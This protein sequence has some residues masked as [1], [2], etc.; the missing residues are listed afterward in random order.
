MKIIIIGSVGSGKTTLAKKLSKK[1]NIPYYEI[2]CIVHDDNNNG[3]KRTEAE[4]YNIIN[5]INKNDNWI[6]EGTLREH[7]YYLLDFSDKI[8]LVDT[9]LYK[10]KI[11][12]FTRYIKQKLHKEK[13]NY[14]PNK[15]LL[16]QMYKWTNDFEHNR[17][18]LNN[19]LQKYIDK[20]EIIK[21]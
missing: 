19:T 7:L 13:C 8:I 6:I 12:I 17:E 15:E 1:Y 9:P 16:K 5:D 18:K 4:Q 2:D 14:I 3:K 11:R 21:Q 10:R 20:V